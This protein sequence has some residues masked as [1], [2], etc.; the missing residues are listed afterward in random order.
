MLSLHEKEQRIFAEAL[1]E[2]AA[3]LIGARGFEAVL[4]RILTSV[5]RVVPHDGANIMLIDDECRARVVARRGYTAPLPKPSDYIRTCDEVSS[6]NHMRLTRQPV[7]I[8]DTL[9]YEGWTSSPGS[10]WVRSY[11][12][13]PIILQDDVVG[14]LNLDSAT[15]YFFTAEH[16]YRLETFAALASVAIEQAQLYDRLRE[17]ADALEQRIVERTAQLQASHARY[18][19]VVDE[20]PDLV[21]RFSPGGVITFVNRTVAEILG[22][23]PN[24]LLGKVA[25]EL[26]PVDQR[27]LIQAAVSTLSAENPTVTL[28][29]QLVMPDGNR[30][31]FQWICSVI[32]DQQ[33]QVVEHQAVGRNITQRKRHEEQL[34][35]TLEHQ[36][37][38]NEM[39]TRYLAMAAHDLRNPLAVIQSDV[40]MLERYN[41]RL[42]DEDKQDIFK[43]VR[44]T[45]RL[46]A[47]MFDDILTIGSVD[48]G[49]Q[50]FQP[51][52]MDLIRFC[53]NAILEF[54][55]AT[56]LRR[57]LYFRHEG[58]LEDVYL[59]QRL[60]RHIFSNLVSNAL[61]YSPEDSPV[62]CAIL[63]RNGSVEIR[64][65]DYGM[66]IPA[67]EQVHLFEAFQRASNARCI[68]GTGLGLAIVKR[69]VDVHGGTISF[70]SVEGEG[71][72]FVVML[73]CASQAL[74]RHSTV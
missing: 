41:D 11:T 27:A 24:V 36:M 65:Q 37:N 64:V 14:F 35:V 28:E 48:S 3:A 60:L 9:S 73:P 55:K 15:P 7:R 38:V 13:A 51:G 10:A 47:T 62:E 2:A 8:S 32:Q 4:D 66:G 39:R 40:G 45:T 49:Q 52:C 23:N 71:S 16:T 42:S 50:Q 6:L 68:S 20:S 29:S 33:G 19:A 72:T 44:N 17:H 70:S 21:V 59:D 26:S 25:I 31:W 1:K 74:D 5:A 46:M 34:N 58:D 63:R 61:K 69:C 30:A 67:S 56:N 53:E 12:A 18:Q 54:K 57:N 22:V 43:R